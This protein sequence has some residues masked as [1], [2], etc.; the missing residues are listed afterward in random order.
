MKPGLFS[1][2][3]CLRAIQTAQRF[4]QYATGVIILKHTSTA[5]LRDRHLT[6]G[7]ATINQPRAV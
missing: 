2:V 4:T 1:D 5:S 6:P 3:H 7:T